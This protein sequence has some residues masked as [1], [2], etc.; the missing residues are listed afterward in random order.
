MADVLK[1]WFNVSL[2]F[3]FLYGTISWGAP[4]TS[5]K[6]Q[7]PKQQKTRKKHD[8]TTPILH[9]WEHVPK[10]ASFSLFLRESYFHETQGISL[11]HHFSQ[12]LY[13]VFSFHSRLHRHQN[14][15]VSDAKLSFLTV[16]LPWHFYPLNICTT[17][18]TKDTAPFDKRTRHLQ[19]IVPQGK[20]K[21]EEFLFKYI[22]RWNL[23]FSNVGKPLKT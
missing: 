9:N 6:K 23:M 12:P 3:C 22:N 2:F 14:M 16:L 19:E 5:A 21:L 18:L 11:L 7:N 1:C 4:V 17:I 13:K 20:N 8:G 10:R 15:F